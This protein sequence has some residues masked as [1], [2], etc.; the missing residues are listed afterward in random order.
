M[1]TTTK[2]HS[3]LKAAGVEKSVSVKNGKIKGMN[4]KLPGYR[5]YKFDFNKTIEIDF[6]R[7]TATMIEKTQTAL[8]AASITYTRNGN[9]FVIKMVQG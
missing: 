3:I 5:V 1:I 6:F 4:D 7:S 8:D 2:I 9:E